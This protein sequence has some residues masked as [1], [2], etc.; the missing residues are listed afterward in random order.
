MQNIPAKEAVGT[1]YRNAFICEPDWEFI[2]SDFSS[3]E[4]V[5]IAYIS[6]DPVWNKALMHGEDLHSVCAELVFPDKAW[7]KSA[8][9]DCAYYKKNDSGVLAKQKCKCKGHKRMRNAV[10]SI[11]FGLA[12]G[13]SEFKLS[14]S[15]GISLQEAKKLIQDY[16]KAFPGIGSALN[17]L[18]YFGVSKGYIQTLAPFFR[19]R[20]FPYWRYAKSRIEDHVCK[21]QYD[22]T[23]GSIERASKNQ[24]IQGTAADITKV[25][26]LMLYWKC[27]EPKWEGKT[28]LVMQVHDQNTTTCLKTISKE[29]FKVVD[30][31]MKEAAKF[32]IPNG[33]LGCETTISPV[34][35]K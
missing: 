1:R 31:T 13:M 7:E 33:L 9:S 35:T 22:P 30:D 2:D 5:I 15:L 21:I 27:H 25:S 12:Y 6:G 29:W 11:N 10:K 26:L 17:Y 3:Q 34:W 23:L 32:I 28:K 16:F 19:K 8:E 4:L 24:P 20:W 14:S 18:G